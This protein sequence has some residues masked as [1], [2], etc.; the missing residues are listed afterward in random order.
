MVY[1]D[2]ITLFETDEIQDDLGGKSEIE[3]LYKII[4]CTVLSK[5]EVKKE[6]LKF[7][8]N[9]TI[10]KIA[11]NDDL[12]SS[13]YFYFDNKKLILTEQ[14]DCKEVIIAQFEEVIS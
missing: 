9:I 10:V 13:C 2:K 1:H 5:K 14:K 7:N 12:K 4:S 6:Q 3:S 11:T 8:K